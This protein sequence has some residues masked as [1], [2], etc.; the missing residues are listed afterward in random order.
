MVGSL[1]AGL[2]SASGELMITTGGVEKGCW[3]RGSCSFEGVGATPAEAVG[4]AQQLWGE[5]VHQEPRRGLQVLKWSYTTNV[6]QLIVGL[7]SAGLPMSLLWQQ[8]PTVGAAAMY[9]LYTFPEG[10]KGRAQP[11]A[12]TRTLAALSLKTPK[13]S[14]PGAYHTGLAMKAAAS[15]GGV[16]GWS[17]D[18]GSSWHTLRGSTFSSCDGNCPHVPAGGRSRDDFWDRDYPMNPNTEGK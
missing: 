2:V 8:I 5:P 9:L 7:V 11:R 16:I 15:A 13:G 18:T 4:L 14:Q 17:A 1:L 12:L 10:V 6:A 3:V